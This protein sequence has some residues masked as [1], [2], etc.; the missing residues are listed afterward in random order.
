[1]THIT[2]GI[3]LEV[4]ERHLL[5]FSHLKINCHKK[6]NCSAI[7]HIYWSSCVFNGFYDISRWPLW[8]L[9]WEGQ[10]LSGW[11]LNIT[12]LTI[13][14]AG[15]RTQLLTMLMMGSKFTL[16]VGT[17]FLFIYK[18]PTFA[19][20]FFK[21]IF[22]LIYLL[23]YILIYFNIYNLIHLSLTKMR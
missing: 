3:C 10:L 4:P 2:V 18:M 7:L 11:F 8:I 12:N 22:N 17:Y 23:K 21:Y 19:V 9:E 13:S 20:V 15:F 1:M 5:P 6:L 14:P 16:R